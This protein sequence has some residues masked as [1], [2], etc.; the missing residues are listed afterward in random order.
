MTE[1]I[2]RL[3]M[4]QARAQ[5]RLQIWHVNFNAKRL[6]QKPR[7]FEQRAG[8]EKNLDSIAKFRQTRLSASFAWLIEILVAALGLEVKKIL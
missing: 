4:L 5:L 6:L 8:L 3:L 1:W 7:L 2:E